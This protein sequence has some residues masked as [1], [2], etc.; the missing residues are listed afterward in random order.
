MN[1]QMKTILTGGYLDEAEEE[2]K[3]KKSFHPAKLK[4]K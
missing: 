3:E 2:I 1:R 4:F